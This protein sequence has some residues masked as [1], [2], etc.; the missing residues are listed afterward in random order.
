MVLTRER[1]LWNNEPRQIWVS[2]H[3]ALQ[4]RKDELADI[5]YD[6]VAVLRGIR[7]VIRDKDWHTAE[8]TIEEATLGEDEIHLRLHHVL[9]DIDV[10]ANLWLRVLDDRLEVRLEAAANTAFWANR[11]GVVAQQPPTLAGTG[12]TVHHADGTVT[13]TVF[14]RAISPHQPAK[15]VA[16]MHWHTDGL[17]VA[18]T[19]EG[20]EFEIEDQRNWTDASYKTYTPPLDRPFP[21]LHD[22]GQKW[23][24]GIAIQVN[25]VRASTQEPNDSTTP[26][27]EKITLVPG[28]RPAPQIGV[29]TSTA[30][31]PCTPDDMPVPA[32]PADFLLVEL[33]GD[34][35][36]WHHVLARATRSDIP[37]DV[38]IVTDYPAR[39]ETVVDSLRDVNVIRVGVF[40]VSTHVT[41]PALWTALT[42]ALQKA[43]RDVPLVGGA[44]SHYTE[45]N[46][47]R[48]RLPT[49]D[50]HTF[51]ITPQMHVH[52]TAQIVESISMQYLTSQNASAAAEGAPVHVG[53]VTLRPRFNAVATTPPPTERHDLTAGYDAALVPGATDPRQREAALATWTIASAAALTAGGAASITYFEQWGPRGIQDRDGTPF[54]VSKAL[55]ELATLRKGKLLYH[56]SPSAHQLVWAVGAQG[57]TG[58]L[59]LLANLTDR[60]RSVRVSAPGQNTTVTLRPWGWRSVILQ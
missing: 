52:E 49:M 41:E 31:E 26:L 16:E 44:R 10:T 29:G 3:W 24:Q 58:T 43:G 25:G 47:T 15:S 42:S 54:P 23:S 27:S 53:P 4:L 40:A 33:H 6:G 30:P 20:D 32:A 39:V 14:P 36:N 1:V 55:A 21:V 48:S 60:D 45:L 28:F 8:A 38:R 34:N 2:K 11:V 22:I 51:S 35:P 56:A 57:E 12:L 7:F 59:V 50:S 46:R 5:T 19:F 9:D 18:M 37:L 17:D 13:S